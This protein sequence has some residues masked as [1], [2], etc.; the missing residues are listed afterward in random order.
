MDYT[1]LLSVPVLLIL[2]GFLAGSESALTSLSR[3]LIEEIIEAKPKL[4]KRFEVWSAQPSKYLNVLL[5][6]RKLLEIAAVIVVADWVIQDKSNLA[7]NNFVELGI[8]TV[9][10]VVLSYVL[11][12]V[13]PRTL[14]K[15]NAIKWAVPSILVADSLSKVLGP[16]TQLLIAFG[17]AITPVR[18]LK[19]DHLPMKPNYAIW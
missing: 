16:I 12:G 4:A 15:Q 11:V 2:A 3:V 19:V 9:V 17:N 18:V 6:A 13:G 7:G 1:L 8:A 10:M 5:F 14:G